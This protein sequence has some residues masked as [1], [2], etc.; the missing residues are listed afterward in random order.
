MVV[1]KKSGLSRPFWIELLS[2]SNP[3]S[4][5]L[6]SVL[7]EEKKVW[8]K[9]RMESCVV[10]CCVSMRSEHAH[11]DSL[12]PWLT[13]PFLGHFFCTIIP[14]TPPPSISTV[15][16]EYTYS[17]LRSNTVVS[18]STDTGTYW[19]GGLFCTDRTT[20]RRIYTD[21]QTKKTSTSAEKM[22]SEKYVNLVLSSSFGLR[23]SYCTYLHLSP[24][25]Q[26]LRKGSSA[27][28]TD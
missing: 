5:L 7:W 3:Y 20:I 21:H 18:M 6:K 22:W 1:F 15:Q 23:Y 16:Y 28:L 10:L 13:V 17:Y 25:T 8:K 19:H 11:H 14:M 2:E 4:L 9:N 12:D 26:T 27:K 24:P